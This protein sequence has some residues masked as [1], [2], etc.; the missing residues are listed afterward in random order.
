MGKLYK[1]GDAW[2]ADYFDRNGTRQRQSTR[3]SDIKVARASARIGDATLDPSGSYVVGGGSD[4]RLRY[5]D[6][7]TGRALWITEAHKSAILGVHFEERALV[8]RGV[9]GEVSRWIVDDGCGSCGIV[10]P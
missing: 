6:V 3:T 9:G 2:Y 7:A 10:R 8:T 5:W 1:R 4:G